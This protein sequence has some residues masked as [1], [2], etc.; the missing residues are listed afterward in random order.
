MEKFRDNELKRRILVV[1]D[2]F[3]NREILSNILAQNY[4]VY[5]A[6]DGEQA[7]EMLCNSETNFSLCLLDLLMPKMDGHELIERIHKKEPP[8]HVPMIV[9][10]SE[11][12]AEV[13]SIRLGAA[14]FITKPYVPEVVL[15]RVERIIELFEGQKIIRSTE[16]DELT[17]LYTREYFFAYIRE[18]EE[19]H[20]EN[21]VDALAF[22]LDHM[23][24]I[25]ECYGRKTAEGILKQIADYL[26]S[27]FNGAGE[28]V[29][30]AEEDVFYVYCKHRDHYEEI[31]EQILQIFAAEEK[32]PRIR[33]RLGVYSDTGFETDAE[34]RFD[35]AKAASNQIRGDYTNHVSFYSNELREKSIYEERLVVDFD[36]S[37]KNKDFKVF[38][39]PK[40]DISGDEPRL[41][42]AEALVRWVHPIHGMISPGVFVPL[43]EK[44]GLVQ[45]LDRYVWAEAAAQIK[46]WKE[47]YGI[48]VPVSVNVSR[49]DIF[50][51]NI[52]E[53]LMNLLKENGLGCDEMLLEVTES[54]YADDA[55]RMVEMVNNLRN[56]G[57]RIE[58]D[59]FGS[60]YS[61]LNMLATIPVDILKMDMKFIQNMLK[62]EKSLKLVKLIMDIAEFLRIPVVAEGVEE[63]AQLRELKDM[64]CKI[65]QGYYFSKP[66]P[67]EDFAGFIKKEKERT[68]Q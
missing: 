20:R 42:S 25:N 8:C 28:I 61:S 60:G 52:E 56:L 46:K 44:N 41:C 33:I 38:Y 18:I 31:L 54:A 9:L 29:C 4:D 48:T 35:R 45:K 10:T 16:R 65:I 40:Y 14:D 27:V 34:T 23:N 49:I 47:E 51:P 37:V 15:A 30:R 5:T 2:E 55:D 1:D 26:P 66:V 22:C 39:Q 43:F 53:H 17:G 58:M 6:E 21:P 62:D 50:D 63:E 11:K 64:G 67:A 13:T 57:F 59:D 32:G 68:G 12:D 7:Y 19:Y 36:D 24:L 3:I